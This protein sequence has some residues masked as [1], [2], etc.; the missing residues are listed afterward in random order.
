M[1]EKN[2]K[3]EQN[4]KRLNCIIAIIFVVLLLGLKITN[5]D[6]T[7]DY[8]AYSEIKSLAMI[9][10]FASITGIL[11]YGNRK[12]EAIE[13]MEDEGKRIKEF[14]QLKKKKLG[15]FIA[16]TTLCIV[17]YGW[18]N[19]NSYFAFGGLCCLLLIAQ[20]FNRLKE[21]NSQ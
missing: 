1:K 15:V 2:D 20:I 16:D 11:Y 21:K 7:I 18:L 5:S 12:Q 13:K 3:K 14:L 4:L 17:L 8:K 19:D 9:V 10:L 6:A